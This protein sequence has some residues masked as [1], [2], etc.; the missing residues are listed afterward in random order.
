MYY[1]TE[2]TK[3]EQ[4]LKGDELIKLSKHGKYKL[5]TDAQEAFYTI[6]K[7]V[8][9]PNNDPKVSYCIYDAKWDRKLVF[10]STYNNVVYVKTPRMNE[11][12]KYMFSKY[13][14]EE[15]RLWWSKQRH[16]PFSQVI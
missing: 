9:I 6:V 3:P 8:A 7:E 14:P 1:I 5:L 12:G 11:Y 10:F 2:Y 16:N 4:H 13:S 15:F